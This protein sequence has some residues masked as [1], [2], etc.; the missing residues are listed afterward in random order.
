V[1][2]ARYFVFV[3]SVLVALLFAAGWIWPS[4]GPTVSE[5]P[6]AQAAADAPVARI[7]SSQ[8]WPDK[9][10]FDTSKPTLAPSPL[11][12]AAASPAQVVAESTP[13]ASP[14]DARAEIKP[15]VQVASAQASRRQAKLH[16]RYSRQAPSRWAN[17]NPM[18]PSWSWGW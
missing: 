6:L 2:I 9:I 7:H 18:A 16:H 15:N 10:E 4:S 14:L 5:A 12:A 3:G 1:P 13:A 11:V 8:K 17:A